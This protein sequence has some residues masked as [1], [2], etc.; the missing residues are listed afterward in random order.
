M[1]ILQTEQQRALNELPTKLEVLR[2][3]NKR[4]AL[5]EDLITELEHLEREFEGEQK[6]LNLIEE[7]GEDHWKVVRHAP[8]G[9]YGSNK[10]DLLLL[11]NSSIHPMK[12]KN[13]TGIFKF[14]GS[15]CQLNGEDFRFHP[16]LETQYMTMDTKETL[17]WH[18]YSLNIEGTLIFID[19]HSE[20]QP[21]Y[22]PDY[23]YDYFGSIEMITSNQ[24]RGYIKRIAEEEKDHSGPSIN[25][26]RRIIKQLEKVEHI[27]KNYKDDKPE[28]TEEIKNQVRTGI[29]CSHCESFDLD[30]SRTYISCSCG[31]Y[32]PRENAIVRTIC[33]YG[34]IHSD[35]DLRTSEVL[36]FFGG[37]ISRGNLSRHLKEHFMRIGNGRGT[38]YMNN[39]QSIQKSSNNFKLKQPRYLEMK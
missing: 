14:I 22:P 8:V 4:E 35:K 33:E 30:M 18:N 23:P 19:K 37:D 12:I 11:T 5:N 9:E 25:D 15:G 38:K 2:E 39:K 27:A 3:L 31:M 21:L 17:E 32:E 26:K 29:C 16:I 24:V 34:V 28:I 10:C 6:V 1:E 13:Y 7:F 20:A 36:D